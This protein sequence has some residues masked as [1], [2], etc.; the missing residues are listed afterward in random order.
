MIPTPYNERMKAKVERF[1]ESRHTMASITITL[2]DHVKAYIERQI[3][4]GRFE[5]EEAAITNAVEQEMVVT[6]SWATDD[7]LLDA[8]AGADRGE[9]RP[10]TEQV[11]C[12]LVGRARENARSGHQVRPDVTY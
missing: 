6:Q 3:A 8:I 4:E 1:H 10:L 12:E 9:T 11:M 2:P 5:S 7:T